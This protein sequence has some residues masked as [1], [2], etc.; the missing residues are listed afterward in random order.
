MAT[1]HVGMVVRDT[2]LF[3]PCTI[4]CHRLAPLLCAEARD[5]LPAVPHTLPEAGFAASIV[6]K[7]AAGLRRWPQTA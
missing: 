3:I 1:S 5:N 2:G 4:L 7:V 6:Q